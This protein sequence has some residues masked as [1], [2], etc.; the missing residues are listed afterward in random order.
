MFFKNKKTA[1]A[2]VGAIRPKTLKHENSKTGEYYN[3]ADSPTSASTSALN[4][5]INAS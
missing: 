5:W 1:P 4:S 3:P 2:F